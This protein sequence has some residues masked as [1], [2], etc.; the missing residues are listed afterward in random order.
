MKFLA[1]ENVRKR[2]VKT[3]IKA[4]HE[5]KEPKKGIKNSVLFSLAKKEERILLTN[6][7]DF[8]EEKYSP[9]KK[10]GIIVFRVFPD[11]FENQKKA[12][13]RLLSKYKQEKFFGN[14]VELGKNEEIFTFKN[15]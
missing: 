6:D 8:L 10:I 2:L 12:L 11:T 4:G 15:D 14:V 3:L 5:V 1:D 13:L 7:T 9:D